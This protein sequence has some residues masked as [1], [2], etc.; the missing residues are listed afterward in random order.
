MARILECARIAWDISCKEANMATI[1]DDTFGKCDKVWGG[2]E[3]LYH[4]DSTRTMHWNTRASN[5]GLVS[6]V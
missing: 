4:R 5:V 6:H 2:N 1:Y 3:L